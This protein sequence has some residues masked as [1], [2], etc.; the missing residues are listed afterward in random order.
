MGV[1]SGSEQ[2]WQSDDMN[3][4]TVYG[5]K[6]AVCARVGSLEYACTERGKTWQAGDKS[7]EIAKYRLADPVKA[8]P[9]GSGP[10]CPS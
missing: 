10:E 9:A 4:S 2:Q 3:S 5:N 7:N 8:E 1:V 6:A